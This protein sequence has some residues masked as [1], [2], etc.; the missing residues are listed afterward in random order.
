[1]GFYFAFI[2]GNVGCVYLGLETELLFFDWLA[3][4]SSRC[5]LDHAFLEWVDANMADTGS[6]ICEAEA[7]LTLDLNMIVMSLILRA[8]ILGRDGILHMKAL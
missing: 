1:M 2:W 3:L 4:V 5:M 7:I 8:Y 6:T